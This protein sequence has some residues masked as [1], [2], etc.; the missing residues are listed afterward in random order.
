MRNKRTWCPKCNSLR[1]K[2]T[3]QKMNDDFSLIRR[4]RKCLDCSHTF[5][6]T[7]SVEV[8]DDDGE[9]WGLALIE[10]GAH[11]QAKFTTS[12]VRQIRSAYKLQGVTYMDLAL[13]YDC[14]YYTIAKIITH[15]SYQGC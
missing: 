11:P 1:T 8:H 5:R 3:C 7:Q 10:P 14:S 9:L 13:R 15:T 6:T 4:Y 2:I 12:Q